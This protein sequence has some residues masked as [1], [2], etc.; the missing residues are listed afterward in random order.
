MEICSQKKA[1]CG[2][3]ITSADEK[4]DPAGHGLYFMGG[5]PNGDR[6]FKDAPTLGTGHLWWTVEQHLLGAVEDFH[7]WHRQGFLEGGGTPD[8]PDVP[9]TKELRTEQ[10]KPDGRAKAREKVFVN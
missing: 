1:S 10:Y 9:K 3:E 2:P 4:A 6:Q 7:A 8:L 5:G